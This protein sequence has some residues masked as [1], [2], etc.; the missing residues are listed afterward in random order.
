MP[1]ND[2]RLVTPRTPQKPL[3]P[4]LAQPPGGRCASLSLGE[5]RR[6]ARLVEPGLLA[7]H[8]PCVS[9]Q[10]AG[11]LERD[12]QLGIRLDQCPR[13]SMPHGPGLA[14]G[15]AAVNADAEVVDAFDARHLERREREHPVRRTREVLLDR[16]AVEPRIAV[17]RAQDHA[18]DRRL[19]LARTH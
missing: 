14:A 1:G 18:R 6:L 2:R 12:A 5:L 16:A 17:A 4:S 8:D 19:A 15:T 3:V 9:G 7:L 10:E 13:D 11:P